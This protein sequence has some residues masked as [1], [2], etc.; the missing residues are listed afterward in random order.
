MNNIRNERTFK[1]YF[2]YIKITKTN[3]KLN[4]IIIKMTKS[5]YKVQNINIYF[6][7]YKW[8]TSH[9]WKGILSCSV[10]FYFGGF[11]NFLLTEEQIDR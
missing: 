4:R 3:E 10:L 7:T 9:A 1:D 8:G 5:A 11:C 6:G 2:N